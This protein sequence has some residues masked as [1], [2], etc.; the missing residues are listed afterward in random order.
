MCGRYT[1]KLSWKQIAEF[2]RL[3]VPEE[4]PESDAQQSVAE[5]LTAST[6]TAGAPLENHLAAA[7][8]F[9]VANVST[10]AR[11]LSRMTPIPG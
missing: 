8:Y 10:N 2:Y 1:H 6:S 3:T 11:L 5:A 7:R 4:P 9:I